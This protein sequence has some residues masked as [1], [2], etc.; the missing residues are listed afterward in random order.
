MG[1]TTNRSL[2][3]ILKQNQEIWSALKVHRLRP[4]LMSFVG[5]KLASR[6][7]QFLTRPTA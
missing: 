4:S 7:R 2:A 5:S 1:G 6:G 3:N